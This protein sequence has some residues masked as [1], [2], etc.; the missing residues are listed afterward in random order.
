MLP[1]DYISLEFSA[2][3]GQ[4][5][6]REITGREEWMVNSVDT[7]V[8]IRL[9]D[10]LLL[11]IPGVTFQPGGVARLASADRERMLLAVYRRL[12]GGRVAT[13]LTC[14]ACQVQ[15]DLDFDLEDVLK[16]IPAEKLTAG[17]RV[18]G[19]DYELPGGVRFRL[20]TGEDELAI[21][22]LPRIQA[23]EALLRRCLI[24]GEAESEPS[25]RQAMETIA[26][27]VDIDLDCRCPECDRAQTVR[28]DLQRY[29]LAAI[30]SEQPRLAREV[31][32]LAT[33]YG[34]KLEEILGLPR[35]QRR[36]YVALVE[37]AR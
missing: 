26:P 8:A 22:H 32:L 37:S 2:K 24:D 6:L 23:E 9:L 15:F 19:R 33:A 5:A 7:L 30:Q 25:V 28:F 14:Q 29:L 20:P 16:A 13:T 18:N 31:H 34:W 36:M 4:V 12:Y 10:C 3:P 11:D 1:V 27:V 21:A 35:S 17:E